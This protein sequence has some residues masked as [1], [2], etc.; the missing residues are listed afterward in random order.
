MRASQVTWLWISNIVFLLF[1]LLRTYWITWQNPSDQIYSRVRLASN[2]FYCSHLHSVIN[3]IVIGSISMHEYRN[4]FFSSP[5]IKWSTFGSTGDVKHFWSI[6]RREKRVVRCTHGP[7]NGIKSS[8]SILFNSF[9]FFS[10]SL[11]LETCPWKV[12]TVANG[13]QC[14]ASPTVAS[15]CVRWTGQCAA[16]LDRFISFLWWP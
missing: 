6:V 14:I 7:M 1:V 10:L 12:F 3:I 16:P 13:Q 15:S 11:S 9:G 8:G 2:I 5:V 4:I